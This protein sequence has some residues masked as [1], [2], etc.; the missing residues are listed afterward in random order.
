VS[1]TLQSRQ[2]ST[3]P[4]FSVESVPHSLADVL[5]A[6]PDWNRLPAYLHPRLRQMLECCLAKKPRDRYT[7]VA[8][9]RVDIEA[10][11][12]D[13]EG[14]GVG[15]G[16]D[17]AQDPAQPAKPR[18]W[19]MAA[20]FAVGVAAT[21]LTVWVLLRPTPPDPTTGV[22]DHYWPEMLPGSVAAGRLILVQNWSGELE[23]LAPAR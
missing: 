18:A 22:V 13:P 10:A 14:A 19:P 11:L 2:F 1:D 21:G 12:R 16:G 23:R 15:L 5:R 4:L 8:D 20:A 9:A 6:D 3:A 17:G 7:G